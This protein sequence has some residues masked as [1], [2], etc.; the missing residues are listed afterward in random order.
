VCVRVIKFRNE[1]VMKFTDMKLSEHFSEQFLNFIKFR[2]VFL[3]VFQ[4]SLSTSLS[5]KCFR[6]LHVSEF[7]HP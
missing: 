2:E 6:E 7:H 1:G 3:E 5:E 4:R